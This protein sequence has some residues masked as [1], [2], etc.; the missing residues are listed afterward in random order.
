MQPTLIRT[1]ILTIVF[2][3]VFLFLPYQIEYVLAPFSS[4]LPWAGIIALALRL[5][6][7]RLVALNAENSAHAQ[8]NSSVH[9]RGPRPTKN[10]YG[11]GEPFWSVCP[12]I[13]SS[14]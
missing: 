1:R 6:Y 3:S 8:Q 13:S 9:W 5:L 7:R 14:P 12:T 11:L 2:F 10:D 4:A